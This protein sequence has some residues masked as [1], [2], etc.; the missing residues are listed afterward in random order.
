MNIR[1]LAATLAAG[2][3]ISSCA[4][5]GGPESDPGQDEASSVTPPL[6]PCQRP[7]RDVPLDLGVQAGGTGP[8]R[9]EMPTSEVRRLV[10]EAKDSGADIISTTASWSSMRPRENRPYDWVALDR[11]I[12]AA[13]RAELKVRLTLQTMPRWAQDA[14]GSRSVWRAPRSRGELRRWSTFVSDLARHVGDRVDYFEVWT[15]PNAIEGW[16][17]GP[18]PEEFARLLLTTRR[19]LKRVAPRIDM[20]SGGLSGN[21]IGFL[22]EVYQA[23]EALGGRPLFDQVGV[24]LSADDRSPAEGPLVSGSDFG[25]Y[26]RTFMGYLLVREVMDDNGDADVPMYVTRFGYLVDR[27]S[28]LTDQVRAD[29]ARQAM[30]VASCDPRIGALGWYNFHRTRYDKPGWALLDANDRPTRTLTAIRNW[31]KGTSVPP[32]SPPTT[33]G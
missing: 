6:P 2:L 5:T 18:D 21:A 31:F 23:G 3:V 26:D 13:A 4:V 15:D 10:A 20:V 9:G 1:H 22:D 27:E 29:Y 7:R 33:E 32:S 19:T 24:N 25:L 30:Y 28:G 12:S 17:T 16:A 11:V 8:G 14:P